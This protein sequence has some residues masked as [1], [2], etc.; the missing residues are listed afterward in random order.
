MS[1]IKK[2]ITEFETIGKKD[3]VRDMGLELLARLVRNN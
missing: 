3:I 1:E 2:Y